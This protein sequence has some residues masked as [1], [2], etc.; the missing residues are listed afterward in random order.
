MSKSIEIMNK[1]IIPFLRDYLG[2]DTELMKRDVSIRHSTGTKRA[3]LVFYVSENG[4]KVPYLVV[5]IKNPNHTQDYSLLQTELYAQILKAP[6]FLITDGENWSWYETGFRGSGSSSRA[7]SEIHYHKLTGTG[8][9]T[10]FRSMHQAQTVIK[11]CHDIIW[12]EKA[13]IPE[14]ALKELSK[15]LIAKII[16][17][18]EVEKHQKKSYEFSIKDE[19]EDVID[20]KNRI[21]FL[22]LKAKKMDNEIFVDKKPELNL[23]PYSI[24]KI[25]QRLQNYSLLQTTDVEI[26]GE[27][28]QGLL[29]EVYTDRVKGQRFTPRVIVDFMVDLIAPDFQET[30]Y[31]P[32][33]GTGGFLV[34]VLKRIK[35]ILDNTS[36]ENDSRIISQQL[37]RYAQ[38]NLYGTDIEPTVIQ[39]AKANMLVHGDGHTHVRTHDALEF[40]SEVSDLIQV[41]NN[42][43]FDIILTNPPFG[44]I[45]I[46]PDILRDYVLAGKV[47]SELTQV[48][49]IERCL[50]LLKPGGRLGIILPEGILNNI[51]QSHVR[52]FILEHSIL[53][54]VVSLPDVTFKPYGAGPKAS[55]LFLQKKR[56]DQEKQGRIIMAQ[57]EKVGYTAS[58]KEENTEDIST[59]KKQISKLGGIK[60]SK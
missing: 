25:V 22:L 39:L 23:K 2:Y 1:S 49:F 45:K 51:K 5:E 44:G 13:S 33:C 26:L 30:V 10:K 38:D 11:Y 41:V 9:L 36:V 29:K 12:N 31:D 16:D 42:G 21:N 7:D 47:N 57:I 19:K 40:S 46:D 55:I 35:R 32:A 6:Y 53:K 14:E 24:Q 3:D 27:T 43:G 48:L 37:N 50:K 52:K 8:K 54:A 58:G 34:S 59:V 4:E 18:R 28:Y 17:E 60:W 56:T 20:L 15:F